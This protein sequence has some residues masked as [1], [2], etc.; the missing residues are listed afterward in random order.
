M[1]SE[2]N[3]RSATRRSDD[4]FLRRMMGAEE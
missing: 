1:Y 3:R 4:E 2:N